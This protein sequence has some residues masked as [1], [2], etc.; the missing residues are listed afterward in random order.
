LSLPVRRDQL[1]KEEVV[2]LG[3]YLKGRGQTRTRNLRK[4]LVV[5]EEEEEEEEKS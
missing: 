5:G 2:G 3:R 1:K 4:E